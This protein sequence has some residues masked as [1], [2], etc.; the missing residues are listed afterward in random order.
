VAI[1][2]GLESYAVAREGGG[3]ALTEGRIG[4]VLSAVIGCVGGADVV[5]KGGR[6]HLLRS[7]CKTSGTSR[8]RRPHACTETLAGNWG[9]RQQAGKVSPVKVRYR[10]GV[11][12]HL[13]PVSYAIGREAGGGAL[14]GEA[15]AGH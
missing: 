11:A 3:G 1:H 13:G 12:N 4:C 8:R 10:K 2:S 5:W 14:I 6:Q 7:A 15:R 9:K